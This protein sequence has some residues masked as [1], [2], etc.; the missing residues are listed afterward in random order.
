MGLAGERIVVIDGS[1]VASAT[2]EL[3]VV[4]VEDSLAIRARL[5][6][7]I[8]AVQ[9][10]RVVASYDNEL[11]ALAW[12][13]QQPFDLAVIDL[14]LREGSGFGI[15]KALQ[16]QP[17]SRLNGTRRVVLT[18]HGSPRVRA[19][20]FG[21]GADAFFDK[22]SQIEEL[23]DYIAEAQRKHAADSPHP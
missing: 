12:M 17:S 4:L 18:N 1:A 5:A 2:D 7:M 8:E 15:L 23:L 13:Q 16:S 3:R 19:I 6:A 11:E 20:C 22:A 9:A 14:D 21:L 10:C